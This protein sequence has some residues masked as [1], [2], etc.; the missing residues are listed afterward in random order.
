MKTMLKGLL[1]VAGVT[2]AMQAGAQVT[3]YSG[4]GFH[5][6]SLFV[7]RPMRDLDR[8][9]FNDRAQS[10]VVRNGSWQVCS[11]AHFEGHCAILRPRE[12]P[13][14][15]RMGLDKRISSVRPVEQYGRA[16]EGRDRPYEQR[17]DYDRR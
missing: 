10:A 7:D 8:T 16:D 6:H 4:E 15:G 14:L 9:D 17:Y 3:F 13:S 12:Y 2:L 1:A 11:D 5:G